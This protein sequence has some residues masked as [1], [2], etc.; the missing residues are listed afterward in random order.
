G[1]P[2]DNFLD[3][4][5]INRIVDRTRNGGAEILALKKT[6]SANDSPA[7]AVSS[8]VDA[9]CNNRKRIMPCVALLDGEYGYADIAIGVPVIVGAD[10]M[11]KVIELEFLEE[12]KAMFQASAE[13][14]QAD[15]ALLK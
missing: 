4:K 14:V 12:E 2:I 7:A 11:E 8:M 9:V 1:I 5:T 10:G 3:K 13:Q 15:I 6:S